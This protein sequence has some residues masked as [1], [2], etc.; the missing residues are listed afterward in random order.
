MLLFPLTILAL[1]M[2]EHCRGTMG[3]R[4]SVL[5]DISYASYL[6]HF[7]LQ[8]AFAALLPALGL[9]PALFLSP[10]SLVLFFALLIPLSALC[11][12]HFE[13]PMQQWLRR[14]FL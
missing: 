5:G 11:H 2:T 3:R 10:A 6:L 1:A 8:L 9:T 13:L 12:R 4:I 14:R 7:P